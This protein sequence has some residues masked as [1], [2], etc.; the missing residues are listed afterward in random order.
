MDPTMTYE[1]RMDAALA[2][3]AEGVC[4]PPGMGVFYEDTREPA[5]GRVDAMKSSEWVANHPLTHYQRMTTGLT[6]RAV[7]SNPRRA[8]PPT[9]G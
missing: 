5:D 6:T 7:P 4:I 9:C 1:Q 2:D 8:S 3:A